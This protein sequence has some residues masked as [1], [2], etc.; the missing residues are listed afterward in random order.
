[1]YTLVIPA[2]VICN[3]CINIY[4]A[5]PQCM[6]GT[7]RCDAEPFANPDKPNCAMMM[8]DDGREGAT[9]AIINKRSKYPPLLL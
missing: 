5:R 3:K 6:H 7:V 1:M 4:N 9:E 8:I 2:G